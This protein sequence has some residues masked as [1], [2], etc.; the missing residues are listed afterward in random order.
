MFFRVHKLNKI[1]T[2]VFKTCIATCLSCHA[3][4]SLGI[5]FGNKIQLQ[6]FSKDYDFGT[7]YIVAET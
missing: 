5:W 2:C 3:I 7:D 6:T 4:L 1:K